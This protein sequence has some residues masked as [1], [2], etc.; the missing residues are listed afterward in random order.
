MTQKKPMR[1]FS[2]LLLAFALLVSLTSGI[3]RAAGVTD[4]EELAFWDYNGTTGTQLPAQ[5]IATSGKN[6]DTATLQFGDGSVAPTISSQ[7]VNIVNW[8]PTPSYWQIALSTKGYDSITFSAKTRSSGTG[9]RDFKVQI[10]SDGAAFTDVTDSAYQ[11]NTTSLVARNFQNGATVLPLGAASADQE[12]LYIRLLVTSNVSSNGS[13]TIASGGTS[14]IDE[15]SIR[16]QA[17]AASTTVADVTALPNAGALREGD[18][19]LLHTPTVGAIIFYAADATTP[20]SSFAQYTGPIT[21]AFQAGAMTVRA[22]A[23]DPSGVMSPSQVS[24]FS[25]TQKQLG[26]PSAS[27]VPGEISTPTQITLSPDPADTGI[28]TIYYTTDKSDPAIY[29]LPYEAPFTV[30]LGTTVKAISM[31]TGCLPSA[32]ALFEYT[33]PQSGYST[34]GFSG[35]AAAWSLSEAMT[36]PVQAT[37]GDHMSK[38][39]LVTYIKGALKP[40]YTFSSGGLATSGF[41]DAANNAYWLMTTSSKGFTNL[42]L[43][44]KMRSSATGPSEF[45]V[46]WSPDN[47]V[48]SEVQAFTVQSALSLSDPRSLFS[49][50]LPEAAAH[51]DT[52]Y[53]QLVLTST[54]S[55]N[56][57]TIGS[58]GTNTVND[59]KLSGDYILLPGQVAPVTADVEGNVGIGSTVH[60][61]TTTPGATILCS[62]NG[63]DFSAQRDYTF[64]ALPATLYVKAQKDGMT[65]SRVRAISY[66]WKKCQLP[67]TTP[68]AGMVPAG[69]MVSLTAENGAVIKYIITSKYGE[70][71]EPSTER[72]YTNPIA[73][74]SDM[75]PVRITTWATGQGLIDSDVVSYDYTLKENVGGEKNYFGQLH[76]HTTNSDGAGSLDE[77]FTYARDVAG[78]D[79]FAVTDHS[80]SYDTATASDKADKYNLYGYNADNQAWKNGRKAA[81]D[82]SKEDYV[83]FY[84]YEMTWSGG[85]GHINTF[86]TEG[87]VSRLNTELN[88]K[89]SDAGLKAY[90]ELLKKTPESVSQFNH[91]GVT[92]GNFVNFSYIDPVIDQRISLLEVG[93]GEGIIGSGGYFPSY[94]QYVMALDKGWHVAPTNNQDN[95]KKGWGTSNTCRSVVWTNDLSEEGIYQA[96]REMRVYATEV[97]DLEIVYHLNDQP[98]GSVIDGVPSSAHFTAAISNPTASNVVKYASIVTNGG[99][100]LGR[101]NFNTKDASYDFTLNAPVAG[102]YYLKVVVQVGAQERIAVTAPVWL[103]KAE[104]L[105]ITSLTKKTDLPVTTEAL[106][107]ATEFF[108]NETVPATL[109]AVKYETK[110]GAVLKEETPNASLPA[111]GG[112]FTHNLTYTPTIPGETTVVVTATLTYDGKT[113]TCSAELTYNVIDINKVTY[114]GIDA[115]HLNEYVSGNYK[116]SMGNFATMAAGYNVRTVLLW[117]EAEFVAACANPKV[118]MLIVTPPSRRL[119]PAVPANA[120]KSYSQSELDAVAAFAR[121]GRTVIVAGWSDIYENYNY[122]APGLANH[123]AGQQNALLEAIGS[124]LRLG[125]DASVDEKLN[126]SP[127]QYRLYFKDTYNASNALTAGVVPE[128]EYS[129]YGG[130]TVYAVDSAGRPTNTLPAS[131]SP[132]I[133]GLPTTWSI[134]RDGD[135]YGLSDKTKL[136]PRYGDSPDVGRGAGTVLLNASEV[137]THGA[138]SSLVVVSGGAFMSNF[139][140]KVDLDNLGSLQYSNYTIMANLVQSVA[141]PVEITTI[142]DA[143]RLDPGTEVTVEGVATSSVYEGLTPTNKGFFDCIYVQDSTGGINLFPVSAGVS[144]GQTIRVTG[145][146]SAYQGE[147]QLLVSKVS[148]LDSTIAP[149]EPTILSTQASMQPENT[150]LLIKTSGRVT[151]V[152]KEDSTLN[153]V[154]IDDGTGPAIVY[155]NGYITP[156]LDTSFVTEGANITVV[157]LASI[158]ENFSSSD[159]LPRIRVRDRAELSLTPVS[160]D[161]SELRTLIA[162]AEALSATAYRADT[163]TAL[164][165]ALDAAKEIS[166]S[167]TLEA[168]TA[169]R[170]NLQSALDGLVLKITKLSA[171]PVSSMPLRKG[172]TI[173]LNPNWDPVDV[174]DVAL[175]YKSSNPTVLSVSDT[176]LLLAV[177]PG[178]AIVTIMA[179]DGSGL[180]AQLLVTVIA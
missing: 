167:S 85:P 67:Q 118:K 169:A 160:F 98:L 127:N 104:V 156:G 139:E 61:S 131:V 126:P 32:L 38:S 17:K 109:T 97:N 44:F 146:L 116:D 110:G 147:T 130:S 155:I 34:D 102:Y 135:G 6:A 179:G 174:T 105:G 8:T 82:A 63:T 80:N 119:D 114:I 60:F 137:V 48:W 120:H 133:S 93:N 19:I 87:F 52:L 27:P 180:T 78:L 10:S 138:A 40:A 55:A 103:G 64:T 91:P 101:Q 68:G 37:G 171:Y 11:V 170:D 2:S 132:I 124:S 123:M 74:T 142:A 148:L 107:L 59:F 57:G 36:P 46:R 96:L 43:S 58:G 39:Q 158:G 94:E 42:K 100:E 45:M 86:A 31:A 7:A 81:A 143:K 23:K 18:A 41:D 117:S 159:M 51:R 25:Y 152:T 75:F 53:I 121:S 136:L 1:R 14:Q 112:S 178:M 149:V 33:A 150:G 56:G 165:S 72:T 12:K 176:G 3:T 99:V 9:P 151:Q 172:K 90:Y 106:T 70:G 166:E 71:G 62:T 28:A 95:H 173:Q 175:T 111:N 77:A 22:Y 13:G 54:R 122:V 168:F 69:T 88:Q 162:R 50:T 5:V 35:N 163:W 115:S 161:L 140:I 83:G 29:G 92:F 20:V 15:I 66:T 128:Q 141:P 134:D 125:D 153:Q 177:K 26:L 89:G 30:A 79:F 47:M 145:K 129:V 76:A 164:A 21:A 16:G 144:A 113:K 108:N 4:P 65:D 154:T 157:G 73:L 49:F 24:T 84:G